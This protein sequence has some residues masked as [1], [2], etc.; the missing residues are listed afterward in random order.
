MSDGLTSVPIFK[1]PFRPSGKSAPPDSGMTCHRCTPRQVL[2]HWIE[3]PCLLRTTRPS[4]IDDGDG[5]LSDHRRVFAQH[6]E[7]CV[8]ASSVH[9][10]Q[11]H[12]PC[13]ERGHRPVRR[14]RGDR[15]ARRRTHPQVERKGPSGVS[16]IRQAW[17]ARKVVMGRKG[18]IH[19]R[20]RTD[21]RLSCSFE[22]CGW[23]DI[24][25]FMPTYCL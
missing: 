22:G 1:N 9:C 18:C 16:Q 2:Q 11:L 19:V 23:L 5:S 13:G 7:S 3:Q 12:S 17:S 24:S 10:H 15:H 20:L 6:L 21:L 25:S 4:P 14:D 8:W